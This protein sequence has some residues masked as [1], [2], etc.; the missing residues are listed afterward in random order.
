MYLK[1]FQQLFHFRVQQVFYLKITLALGIYHSTAVLPMRLY[2]CNKESNGNTLQSQHMVKFCE[3]STFAYSAIPFFRVL[4]PRWH[5]LY[6]HMYHFHTSDQRLEVW[7][8][9]HTV[10]CRA[11]QENGGRTNGVS[12]LTRTTKS[13]FSCIHTS[14]IPFPNDTK[15]TVEL[16]SSTQGG[17]QIS[18]LR[19][20]LKIRVSKISLKIF[21][22]V[23]SLF[24]FS[25]FV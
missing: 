24:F 14:T 4:T 3:N 16:A 15:F 2:S 9:R 11:A 10:V 25:H 21:F 13:R 1:V 18:N 6:L 17:G 5:G 7:L 22:L 8:S 12:I 20:S 19:R 23:F